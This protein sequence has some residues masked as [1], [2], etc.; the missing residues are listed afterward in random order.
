[1]GNY[2]KLEQNIKDVI[3][4]QQLKL[5][6]RSEV[7]RLY[8]PLSSLNRLLEKDCN[9][10]EMQE[11]LERFSQYCSP[12]LGEIKAECSKERFCL[13]IPPKG[14]EY[15]HENKGENSFLEKLIGIV[16]NHGCTLK[17]IQDLFLAYSDDVFIGK[18]NGE[19][20]DYLFYFRNGIPNDYRYCITVEECHV[21]YHRYTKEDYEDFGFSDAEEI[22]M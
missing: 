15:V 10:G 1:M 22:R 21:I 2:K 9:A 19:D 3:L 6:Y 18:M 12:R 17:D 16:S 20:F 4:E 13:I 8:Y 11:E 5:G 14:A 7:I